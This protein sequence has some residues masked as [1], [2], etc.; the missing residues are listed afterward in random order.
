MA[1]STVCEPRFATPRTRRR[2]YGPQV[3]RVARQ[4]GL[5][6]LPWQRL[7][8]NTALEQVRGRPAY[9]DVLVSVPRQSGK[10]T[11][12]LALIV[13][14]MTAR[15]GSRILY[16]SQTRSAARAKLLESWWPRLLASPLAAELSLFRQYG[17]EA[18][19]HE[20]GSTLQLLSASESA[21]HGETLD[22]VVVDEAWVHQD[23]R[24]EQ[25]TRPAMVTRK[26]AQLW[27]VSTAGTA[28]SSWWKEKLAAGRAAAQMG[29]DTG[30]CCLDWSA[31]PDSNPADE[32]V[33]ASCMPALGRLAHVETVRADFAA[34][35]LEEFSRAYLNLWADPA[36][37]GWKLFE[38][39]LWERARG[40]D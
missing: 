4:I 19:S 28:R 24:H 31:D 39:S 8:L 22:L 33:W 5:D 3:A 21:G 37:E 10:S 7:V 14:R 25:A 15:P 34:M 1:M 9:R 12:M 18:I 11:L 17:A 2:S 35:D 36:G 30:T 40:E 20:N 29:V 27:A 38:R 16:G 32:D 26:D 23:A 13:W 6:L